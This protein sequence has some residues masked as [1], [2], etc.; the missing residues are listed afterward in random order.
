MQLHRLRATLNDVRALRATLKDVRTPHFMQK[1]WSSNSIINITI[2]L[3]AI[4]KRVPKVSVIN[5]ND[6]KCILV[7]INI[8]KVL[9]RWNGVAQNVLAFLSKLNNRLYLPGL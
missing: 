6:E 8:T 4:R 9:A 2:N 5:D 3:L 1:D 7:S